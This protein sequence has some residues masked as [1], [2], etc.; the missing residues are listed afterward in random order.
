M[1]AAPTPAHAPTTYALSMLPIGGGPAVK[2]A[3]IRRPRDRAFSSYTD[4]AWSPDELRLVLG[5]VEEEGPPFLSFVTPDGRL[6]GRV[7]RNASDP[8]WS[9]DGRLVYSRYGSLYAGRPSGRFR[10]VTRRGGADPSWSPD[11]RR[12]AF[13]RKD[14]I[15]VVPRRGGRVRRLVKPGPRVDTFGGS[16]VRAYRWTEPV[17]S[18]DGKR[19]AFIRSFHGRRSAQLF[20]LTLRNR[21]L[22]RLYAGILPDE[23]VFSLDWRALPG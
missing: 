6:T 2:H 1:A 5:G 9:A 10:L 8:D 20:V 22:R 11:G 18:P 7:I 21:K 4:L 17:W 16:P 13:V 12:I 19:L 23:Q 14:G 3:L 15:H